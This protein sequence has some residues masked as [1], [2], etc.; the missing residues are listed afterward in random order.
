VLVA[1]IATR[2]VVAPD[3]LAQIALGRMGEEGVHRRPRVR[4][5]VLALV[6]P[7]LGGKSGRQDQGVRQ[8]AQLL[9]GEEDHVP[10]LVGEDVV[11][12]LRVQHGETLIDLR[13]AR[14]LLIRERRTT[15][16]EAVVHQL[17]QAALIRPQRLLL[18][19]FIDLLDA[20]EELP[21]LGDLRAIFRQP[22]RHLLLHL[23]E[24]L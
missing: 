7:L 1:V 18:L 9:L 15:A 14:L 12:E 3:L 8:A 6:A 23:A 10:L 11:R 4:D 24:L 13:I 16:R 17:D 19:A 2:V 20:L 21:I 22:R 5:G